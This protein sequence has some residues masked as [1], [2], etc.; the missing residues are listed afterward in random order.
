MFRPLLGH[1]QA[2]ECR[3]ITKSKV[4]RLPA[5]IPSVTFTFGYKTGCDICM[6]LGC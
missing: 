1:L 5:G 4:L 3:S 6:T 2:V